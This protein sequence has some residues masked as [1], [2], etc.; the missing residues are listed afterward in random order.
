MENNIISDDRR[1]LPENGET[2]EEEEQ[3]QEPFEGSQTV[4]FLVG[5]AQ[6]L[7]INEDEDDESWM[8]SKSHLK[9]PIKGQ[10]QQD[11][12][13]MRPSESNLKPPRRQN[14]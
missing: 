5:C 2:E 6:G 13:G 3:R 10:V 1:K 8:K 12:L 11:S 9:Q 14:E 7:I 4:Y